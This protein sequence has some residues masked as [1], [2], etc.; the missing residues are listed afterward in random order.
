MQFQGWKENG[1]EG[2]FGEIIIKTFPIS[3]N[4]GMSKYRKHT[5]HIIALTIKIFTTIL[6]SNFQQ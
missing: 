2:I 1:L 6:Q 4:N 5:E 3:R